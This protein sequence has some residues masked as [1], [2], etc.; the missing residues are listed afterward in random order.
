MRKN[1]SR[2][3]D[4]IVLDVDLYA[5]KRN[6]QVTIA[7]D[8][9]PIEYRKSEIFSLDSTY[10]MSSFFDS[11]PEDKIDFSISKSQGITLSLSTEEIYSYRITRLDTL[12]ETLISSIDGKSALSG[13]TISD[14][15][16]IPYGVI[17]YK[18]ECYIT[19][20]PSVSVCLQKEIY[21]DDFS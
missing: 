20:N 1:V 14:T 11:I 7:S 12:G 3:G 2:S 17:V 4:S 5:T 16:P 6:K 15:P 10:P 21:F 19:A 8:F 18:V 13:I 9:T